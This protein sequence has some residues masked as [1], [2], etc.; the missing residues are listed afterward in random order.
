LY[1]VFPSQKQKHFYFRLCFLCLAIFFITP[2]IAQNGMSISEKNIPNSFKLVASGKAAPIIIDEKDAAVVQIVARDF[3]DDIKKV[4]GILPSIITN[5]KIAQTDFV[6]IAGTQGSSSLIDD[7]VKNKKLP[8]IK[9]Q[10]ETYY[11]TLVK[12]P[13]KNIKQAL[14]IAGSDRRGTVFGLFEISRMIGVHPFYWWADI[15]PKHKDNIFISD[16]KAITSHPSVKYRGIFLNDE[17]WGLQPWAA[18]NMDKDFKDIGPRTY[19]KIFELLLRLKANY[20]WPAMHPCT[21]AFWFYKEDAVLADKYAIVLGASHC[22]PMLRDNVF[23]WAENYKEEYKTKPGEWRYDVNKNQ[24]FNYWEDR[25][26]EA[27]HTEAVY[28]VGMRGIHDG[29]MPGPK[30]IPEKVKLLEQIIADQRTMLKQQLARPAADVPQIFCPYKEVLSIYQAGMK[31]PDDVTIVWA[32]D[33]HGYIRQLSNPEEQKRSG[34]S[35]VYYHLSYWGRPQDYLWLSSVSPSLISF[36][37]TKAFDYTADRLWIFN[38][39]DIKPAEAEIQFALELAWDINKWKAENAHNFSKQW[40]TEIF[41]IELGEKIAEIKNDYYRLA[42]SGKPEHINSVSYLE[43]EIN[44]RLADY[45]LISEKAQALKSKIPARLQDAYFQLILYPVE[46]ARLMNE[47]IFYAKKGD[48]QNAKAAYDTIQLLT[49][50]YNLQIQNGKWNGIISSHPRDQKVFE[51]PVI[52]TE[53]DQNKIKESSFVIINASQFNNKKNTNGTTITTIDGLGINAKGVTVLPVMF[54]PFTKENINEASYAEY[55]I[56]PG[57]GNKKIVVKCL[58]T[59]GVYKPNAMQ[60]GI[61]ANGGEIKIVNIE[62][63]ADT[64][65]WDINVL[66]GYVEGSTDFTFTNDEEATIRIYFPQPG[67]V[68]NTIEIK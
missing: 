37:M 29:S 53:N 25:V 64:K 56:K 11:I 17:D 67:L 47:K 30:P 18:K 50:Y 48:L 3:R 33:N 49:N 57:I 43:E 5:K 22:E 32:D 45:K 27:K 54:K 31:L 34:R 62:T 63:E 26:K 68:I 15:T 52:P 51:K 55:K 19:E 9:G 13:A 23:E 20:I 14:V 38:V 2:A 65:P 61:S 12:N 6:V 1:K 41:G 16:G 60:Y 21:K 66:R 59:F 10:W 42:A 58:P 4:T 39:G 7:L 46:G 24:I 35:G 8:D 40:A 36:E 44:K 28:T